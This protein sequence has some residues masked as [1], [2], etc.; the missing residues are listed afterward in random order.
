MTGP[1]LLQITG[2]RRLIRRLERLEKGGGRRV[3]NAAVRK[4]LTIIARGIR[5]EIPAKLQ[6]VR[7]TIGSRFKRTRTQS[8]KQAK[9][10]LSVGKKRGSKAPRRSSR[11]GVGIGARN[12]HWWALGTQERRTRKGRPAGRMPKNNAVGRGYAKSESAA[13]AAIRQALREGIEREA[14]RS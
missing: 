4:A 10:G 1:S 7:R 12:V 5:S 11:G 9:A 13:A 2:D 3:S 6:S 8:E 14:Q